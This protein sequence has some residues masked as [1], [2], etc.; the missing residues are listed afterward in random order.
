MSDGDNADLSASPDTPRKL[1]RPG[2]V[3]SPRSPNSAQP[4][5]RLETVDVLPTFQN[6]TKP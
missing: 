3:Q 6:Q 1:V 2:G 4:R 5:P